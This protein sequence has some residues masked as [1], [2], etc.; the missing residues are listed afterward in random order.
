MSQLV[1]ALGKRI[2]S[3]FANSDHVGQPRAVRGANNELS[4]NRARKGGTMETTFES[5]VRFFETDGLKHQAD[6]EHEVVTAGFEATSLNIRVY[7]KTEEDG[8]LQL[9]A[10]L[11][12]IIPL[13][14]RPAIAEGVARANY[15]MKLG[16]F[17][18]DFS[19][20]EIRFQIASVFPNGNL[21]NDVVRRLI[22]TAVYT[23]NRYFPA[24]MSIVYG[25]EQP[26]DAIRHVEQPTV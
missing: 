15:G 19:D 12:T 17:E 22:G 2:Q 4:I 13:G 3:W 5:L 8:I 16:K 7:F 1:R 24:F 11:P 23:V 14:C 25:N 9:F 20:G 18:L 21:D 6:Y 26:E 10:P